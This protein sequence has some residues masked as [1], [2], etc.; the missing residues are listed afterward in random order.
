MAV[1]R[2]LKEKVGQV[3]EKYQRDKSALIDILHDTQSD[4][5]YLPREALE[6]IHAGLDV[7]L[8][9]IYS[10]ATF[11]KAFSLKPRGRHVINV[12]MGTACHV[13]GS[14][15]VLAQMEKALGIKTGGNTKDLRFTLETVNCVG[16]CALG[17]M[18]IIGEDYHGEM[19]PEK[20]S[21]VLNN[22]D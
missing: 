11:F 16:A 10:V 9:R 21:E 17:P 6:E 19:T 4:I 14:D 22:Y 2:Q 12:C 1:K 15:K 18:V 7:P 13:R 5:G 20:V 8:S 3:L